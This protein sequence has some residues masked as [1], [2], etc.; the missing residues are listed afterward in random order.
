LGVFVGAR[1]SSLLSP[2]DAL[3]ESYE[4]VQRASSSSAAA[5]ISGLG[6]RFAAGT[7][8][9]AQLVR[10]HQDLVAESETLD[11]NIVGAAAKPLAERDL[12]LVEEMRNRMEEIRIERKK[13]RSVLNQ[14][15]P[16]F[17]A[18]ADSQAISASETQSFIME[19][20]AL[21]VFDFDTESYAWVLS[22]TA[23]DWVKL[24]IGAED[25]KKEVRK[26]RASLTFDTD[27]PFDTHLSWKVYERTF[28]L[29]SDK[30]KGKK[31]L[32]IVTNGA[33]TSIP[34]Q[35]LVTTDPANKSLKDVD[36]LVRS[37]SITNLPSVGSLKVLRSAS[38]SFSQKP[39]IAFA[40]PVF[41][42]EQVAQVVTSR[43][44]KAHPKL[45]LRSPLELY[46]SGKADLVAL[47]K[48]LP[49]LPDTATEVLQIGQVLKADK[50]DIKLGMV[51]SE[52]TVKQSK[53]DDYRIVYFA[54]HGLVAG[55][56]EKY[57]KLK[58]E[59]ALALTLKY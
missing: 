18:L 22:N 55:D 37:Y 31:R 57:A 7:S 4:V 58:A 33:F 26:L 5:A 10:H 32:S 19:D 41:S 39:L 49:Q 15:F 30:L 35:L 16:N 6:V 1:N 51:A 48:Y 25:L 56:V 11:E 3:S 50:A 36:W 14:R 46:G 53:L 42:K 8:D 17:A 12:S 54:T 45:A 24:A 9:L 13:I 28:G 2:R 40:D 44:L 47:A 34:F 59:P 27:T 43:N 21:V 52:T 20:E 38:A 23:A 29:I